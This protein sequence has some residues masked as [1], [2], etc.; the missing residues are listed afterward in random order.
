V[1]DQADLHALVDFRE[2]GKVLLLFAAQ[3][4]DAFVFHLFTPQRGQAI[5]AGVAVHVEIYQNL[6]LVEGE[7]RVG[8]R[9]CLEST[10][11]LP[12]RRRTADRGVAGMNAIAFARNFP[13]PLAKTAAKSVS[14]WSDSVF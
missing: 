6:P 7:M 2:R 13:A 1:R 4:K 5:R 3:A 11:G 9:A 14:C 10:T 8:V 12:W